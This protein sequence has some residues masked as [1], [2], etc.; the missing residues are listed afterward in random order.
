MDAL[1]VGAEALPADLHRLHG[2]LALIDELLAEKAREHEPNWPLALAS[3]AEIETLQALE[4]A[5]AERAIEV[6]AR[7]LPG[8]L[9]KLDIWAQLEPGCEEDDL[10]SLRDLLVHSARRDIER[11]AGSHSGRSGRIGP[12]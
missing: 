9:A 10:P 5:V 2:Y 6:P 3:A 1:R 12:Y 11:L 8:V 4:C 7:T